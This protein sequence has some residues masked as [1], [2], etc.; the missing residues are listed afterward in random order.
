[1][2]KI[3][4]LVLALLVPT[5]AHAEDSYADEPHWSLELKGGAF[6]PAIENWD[7]YYGNTN[8]TAF[9]GALAYKLLRQVEMGIG[10]GSARDEGQ[11]VAPGHGTL[12]GQVTYQLYPLHVFVLL[13]GIIDEDQ[14]VVPYVGGGWTRMYYRVKIQEQ[15][16]VSGSADGYHVRAG[17]QFAMDGL[18]QRAANDMYKDYGV[19]HTYFFIEA[20]QTKA[21]VKSV[22]VDLGG[23]AYLMGL[24]FEY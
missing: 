21:M 5:A 17:L 24:L 10:A 15:E 2:K 18:D 11:A 4:L 16:D 3:I 13:R 12:S 7:Q 22:S 1:M 14:W 8:M 23:T 6:T 9:E 20:E 19:Y